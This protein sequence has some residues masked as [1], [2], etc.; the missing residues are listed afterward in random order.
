MTRHTLLV[1]GLI[2]SSVLVGCTTQPKTA[3]RKPEIKEA[4][5]ETTE[6]Y[7]TQTTTGS[8]IPRKVKKSEATASDKQSREAQQA[9][10]DLQQ[11][12]N[13]NRPTD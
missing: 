3:E 2:A 6:E 1:L 5:K 7:V 10:S 11:R 12:G 13:L 8:W 4:K 9:M